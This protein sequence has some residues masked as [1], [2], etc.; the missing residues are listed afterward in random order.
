MIDSVKKY[1]FALEPYVFISITEK[2]V[3]LYNTLDSNHIIVSD[4]TIYN[5]LVNIKNSS[6]GV[7]ELKGF[8]L[9]DSRISRF[10]EEVREKFMGDL[11]DVSLT[12][13]KPFQPTPVLN[14]QTS[15]ERL[16]SDISRSV[17][18]N[19]LFHLHEVL[20]FLESP[21]TFTNKY[22]PTTLPFNKKESSSTSCLDY[23][24]FELCFNQLRENRNNTS[25][26]V[27]IKDLATYPDF[28]KLTT[29]LNETPIRKKYITYYV[30]SLSD[31]HIK[32]ILAENV[33]LTINVDFPINE[34]EFK[35][36]LDKVNKHPLKL[37]VVCMVR[38][39]VE[40][41]L[42]EELMEKHKVSNYQ[43][44]PLFD[45]DNFGF[46]KDN[47]FLTEEDIFATPIS[48]R[49]IFMHQSL[50]IE[51]FGKLAIIPNGDVYS[52]IFASKIGSIKDLTLLQLITK[53][54]DSNQAWFIVRNSKP[55][56]DCLFQ[57]LCPPPSN[58]EYLLNKNNLCLV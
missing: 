9:E 15:I 56:S 14:L 32:T 36:C 25:I 47:I 34:S 12:K 38:S 19:A 55:C 37:D 33:T 30:N 35:S 11:I 53:D 24:L 20:F 31:N 5:L 42:A 1:W 13:D 17:G 28:E 44:N 21:D 27:L 40:V 51:C 23:N 57:W 39:E 2:S 4:K 3:M 7:V 48:M 22:Y 26:S 6:S 54:I 41:S 50:N 52:N 8:L 58:Y 45:G 43:I 18:E 16:K 49:E 29:L 46:F 10:I